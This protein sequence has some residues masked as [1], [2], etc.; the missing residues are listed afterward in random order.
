MISKHQFV[1]LTTLDINYS[2]IF[3]YLVN[4]SLYFVMNFERA[5]IRCYTSSS[6]PL[7]ISGRYSGYC[8]RVSLITYWIS[9]GNKFLSIYS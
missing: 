3:L 4:I 1:L 9:M 8:S 6:V 5:Y 2:N 7:M